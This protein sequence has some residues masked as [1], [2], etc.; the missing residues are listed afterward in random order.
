MSRLYKQSLFISKKKINNLKNIQQTF[1]SLF[2]CLHYVLFWHA[3][4]NYL[5]YHKIFHILDRDTKKFFNYLD[6][7]Y[8][9]SLNLSCSSSKMFLSLFLSVTHI[10]TRMRPLLWFFI[11]VLL[12]LLLIFYLLLLLLL[13]LSLLLLLF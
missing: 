11:L 3:N 6:N 1:L 5:H 13:N 9:V 12:L 10:T 2:Y 7:Y 4:S 8:I